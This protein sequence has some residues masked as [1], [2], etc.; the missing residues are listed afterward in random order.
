MNPEF[1]RTWG[2]CGDLLDCRRPELE[3]ELDEAREVIKALEEDRAK[4][5]SLAEDA[6]RQLR[7][8][9]NEI[10]AILV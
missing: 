9:R 8:L 1:K 7:D 3:G 2:A 4:W 10:Q 5:R 6:M